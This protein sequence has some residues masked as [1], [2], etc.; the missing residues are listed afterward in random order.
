MKYFLQKSLFMRNVRRIDWKE[1]ALIDLSCCFLF[2]ASSNICSGFTCF[3]ALA[4]QVLSTEYLPLLSDVSKTD[5]QDRQSGQAIL[6]NGSPDSCLR[7]VAMA[8]S[9][10]SADERGAG[11]ETQSSVILSNGVIVFGVRER[12]QHH[13]HESIKLLCLHQAI[14]SKQF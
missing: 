7:L 11:T 2:Q 5:R 4:L 10:R 13:H 9:E 6:H 12:T 8:C 14:S 1:Y 3:A